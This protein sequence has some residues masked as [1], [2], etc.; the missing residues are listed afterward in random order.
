MAPLNNPR[1]A[2][3]VALASLALWA[4]SVPLSWGQL[5][6]DAT[7]M[8]DVPITSTSTSIA[9]DSQQPDDPGTPCPPPPAAAAVPALVA[10]LLPTP[11]P[12]PPA[13]QV[14]SASAGAATGSQSSQGSFHLCGP[15]ASAAQAI[16]QLIAGRSFSASLNT[17]ADGCADLIVRATSP[18]GNGS[19]TS[20]LSVSLGNGQNL[21]IQIMSQNGATHVS[22]ASGQ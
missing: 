19:A 21:Q 12:A 13:P 14:P 2:W 18:V 16:E 22:I 17:T 3:S 10:T 20:R 4:T 8:L 15:D 11:P 6:A 7:H 5:S 9:D 1:L